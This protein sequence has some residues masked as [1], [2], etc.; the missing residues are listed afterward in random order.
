MSYKEITFTYFER[1]S[2][3]MNRLLRKNVGYGA[4]KKW[5]SVERVTT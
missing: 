2:K 3:H 5:P 4:L 1:H